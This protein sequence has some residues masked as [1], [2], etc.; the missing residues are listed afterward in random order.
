MADFIATGGQKSQCRTRV[1]LWLLSRTEIA[2][3]AG[4]KWSEFRVR[5]LISRWLLQLCSAACGVVAPLPIFAQQFL[6]RSP[7]KLLAKK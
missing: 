6:E 2:G 5:E 4:R 3:G 1:Y 7:R